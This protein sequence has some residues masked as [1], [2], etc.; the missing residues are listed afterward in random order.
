MK[1]IR[2]QVTLLMIVGLVIFITISMVLY[3]HKSTFKKYSQ[4][5]IKNSQEASLDSQSVKDFVTGCISNLAKDAV[6]L[7]GKQGGYIYRS[8]GGTLADYDP[9]LEGKFFVKHNG[10]NVAYNI[11]P[12]KNRDIPPIYHSEIP[13]YPWLTFPYETETSNT[14]L[15]KG[16]IFGFSGMPPLFSG[17]PHSIQNQIG[18]FID[19]KITS[20]ADLSM[21]ESQGYEVE[22]FDSN[23]TIT[24]GSSDININSIIPIRVTNTLTKQTF[25]MREFS[26]KLDIRLEEIYYFINRLVDEDTT[27][28]TFSIK[29]A[30]NNRDSMKVAAYELGHEDLIAIIDEKSLINGQP[31]QYIFA[32]KNRAPA[33]YYIRPNTLTF[34]SSK[35]QIEEADVLS[36]NTLKAEDPDEDNYNFRI[37]IGESGQTEAVFPAPLNQP[38]MKFRINVS[39]G[40]LSDYQIIT[41]NQQS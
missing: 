2:S 37:F 14:E 40:D 1:K 28:I 13:D 39:D 33:L 6:A 16:P 20:C 26:S 4:Q 7:L 31:Y 22:M 9:T 15:F 38:Q 36:G 21:F 32:R 5:T 17:Q 12:F 41:V 8:Q 27:N 3:L 11:L 35:T 29:D 30:Q 10:Y 25:E 24:I 19:N 18:T 34:D 23:T